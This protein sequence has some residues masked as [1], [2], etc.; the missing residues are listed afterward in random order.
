MPL[1]SV[2]PVTT[3][4]S[5]TLVRWRVFETVEPEGS[6][7]RPTRHFVGFCPGNVEGRVSSPIVSFDHV[8]L[9]G[10][11]ASGRVYALAGEPGTDPDADYVFE[12]WMRINE[13]AQSK[14]VT[15]EIAMYLVPGRKRRRR[16]PG[17]R[18]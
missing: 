4:P 6:G 8:R 10:I 9:R 12:M 3:Q 15:A 17:L 1:W 14:D 2:A 7:Q 5:L 11:T 16:S 13:V 18:A